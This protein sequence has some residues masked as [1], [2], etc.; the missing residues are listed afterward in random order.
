MHISKISLPQVLLRFSPITSFLKCT[1]FL[2]VWNLGRPMIECSLCQIWIHLS[3]AKIRRSNIPELFI[4][5][6]CRE[7]K[8]NEMRTLLNKLEDKTAMNQTKNN[9]NRP[10]KR[11]SLTNS[12]K[13]MVRSPKE[14]KTVEMKIE[15]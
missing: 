4:C 11:V 14:R 9:S 3:C 6:K 1:Y 15:Q 7:E 5:P 8:P 13:D 2:S 12:A 10:K